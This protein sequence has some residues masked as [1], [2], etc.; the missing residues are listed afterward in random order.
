M[1][2]I[3]IIPCLFLLSHLTAQQ[4]ITSSNNKMVITDSL[5]NVLQPMDWI[6][7]IQSGNYKLQR[8]INGNNDTMYFT[9]TKATDAE[10]QAFLQ[11]QQNKMASMPMP[12]ESKF[13]T[14]NKPFNFF[15][16]KD[17]NGNKWDKK[18]LAGKIVVVNFWFI[19]CPPCK[20]E[21]PDLNNLVEKYKTN[22]NV[23]FIGIALDDAYSLKNFLQSTPFNYNIVADG[24]FTA[25][26][27]GVT[28]FPTHVI[29]DASGNSA[30]HTTGLNSN[31]I[32]SIDKAIEQLVK[33]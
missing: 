9:L 17:I 19:N 30:F 24:R 11:Q 28:S 32:Y 12:K 31:T 27:Y 13:F 15:K 20:M 29:I 3:L 2:N 4:K 22:S 33:N 7:K 23:V 16:E 5:G 8:G 21:I 10:R 25:N 14:T 1:K 26:L 6:T 18:T